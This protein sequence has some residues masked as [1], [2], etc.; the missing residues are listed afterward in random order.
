MIDAM[1]EATG[2]AGLRQDDLH[3]DVFCTPEADDARIPGRHR[4]Q[5]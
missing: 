2:A 3:T 4:R 5:A 1:M